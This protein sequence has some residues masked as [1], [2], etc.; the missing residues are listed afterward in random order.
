M[1]FVSIKEEMPPAGK[2]VLGRN[3]A[4]VSDWNPDGIRIC[5]TS[6]GDG[7]FYSSV[8]NSDAELYDVV[9]DPPEEWLKIGYPD[10]AVDLR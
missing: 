10:L 8:W 1:K 6:L 7:K 9:I 2:D 3:G 5:F 4:W